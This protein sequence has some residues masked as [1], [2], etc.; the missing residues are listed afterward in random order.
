MVNLKKRNR[1]QISPHP[2]D[3]HGF[4]LIE[5]VMVIVMIGLLVSIAVQKMISMAKQAE[6]TAEDTTIEILRSNLLNVMGEDL[7]KQGNGSFPENPFENLS[8][9]PLGY[10]HSRKTKPTGL[11]KDRNLW[12]YVLARD[13]DTMT[14]KEAG[15]TL[16]EFNVDG[17]IYHQRKDNV[18]VRWAYDSGAGAISSK[19]LVPSSELENALDRIVES[20][21]DES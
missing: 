9:V 10:D 8:K 4:T 11:D 20:K 7:L 6:I 13:T 15:T 3:Q 21:K 14:P 18:V 17:F 19:F 1:F 5:L 16:K 2:A 12:S